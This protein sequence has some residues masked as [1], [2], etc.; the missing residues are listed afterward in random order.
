MRQLF[1]IFIFIMM[2]TLSQ[3]QNNNLL[4]DGRVEHINYT[5]FKRDQT[6]GILRMDIVKRDNEA[7]YVIRVEHSDNMEYWYFKLKNARTENNV[8]TVDIDSTVVYNDVMHAFIDNQVY[9]TITSDRNTGIETLDFHFQIYEKESHYVLKWKA[10][11][12]NNNDSIHTYMRN[13]P[14]LTS[15]EKQSRP[16]KKWNDKKA[17]EL[18]NQI[19]YYPIG[20]WYLE[21]ENSDGKYAY[22]LNFSPTGEVRFLHL[23]EFEY[24]NGRFLDNIY[25]AREG[26]FEIKDDSFE[27]NFTKLLGSRYNR[28]YLW[29][30]PLEDHLT[31]KIKIELK[32]E[33]YNDRKLIL[34]QVSGADIFENNSGDG[35][36]IFTARILPPVEL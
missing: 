21:G 10:L 13:R 7:G 2:T 31:L 4:A 22:S 19:A 18:M 9:G 36:L 30:D 25:M 15:E 29:H 23:T 20:G 1:I 28:P 17:E 3:A 24:Q 35:T 33:S 8:L 6:G 14:A 5:A 34:T 26:T 11:P 27:I 32:V 16:H 12:N